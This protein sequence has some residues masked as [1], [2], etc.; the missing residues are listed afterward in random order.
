[1]SVFERL[2]RR[3]REV[4]EILISLDEGTLTQVA[5][6]MKSPP[7]RPA[8][9]SIVKI[10]EDKGHLDQAGKRGREHVF[11]P[12][13]RVAREGGSALSKILATFFGGSIK[14]GLTAYLNDP[15]REH[16]PEELDQI[17]AMIRE[18]KK[19]ASSRKENKA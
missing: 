16:D 13:R 9:R 4:M 17:E 15:N 5:A 19:R 6:K 18:A 11:R 1:M 3:E 2:S 7:T 10:L 12:K 8:L 14:D